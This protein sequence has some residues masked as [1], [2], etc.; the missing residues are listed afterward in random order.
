MPLEFSLSAVGSVKPLFGSLIGT[1]LGNGLAYDLVFRL[2][3]T[4]IGLCLPSAL[5]YPTM[6]LATAAGTVIPHRLGRYIGFGL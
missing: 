5:V 2:S 3:L 4:G 6:L 1:A